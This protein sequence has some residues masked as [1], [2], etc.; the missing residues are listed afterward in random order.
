MVS[1]GGLLDHDYALA[2]VYLAILQAN[3]S[4]V[5][6]D[7]ELQMRYGAVD[8]IVPDDLRR[9]V[10]VHALAVSLHMPYETTRRCVGRLIAKGFVTRVSRA[11]MIA[12]AARIA[13]PGPLNFVDQTWLE[14]SRM[15]GQFRRNGIQLDD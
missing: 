10:S 8:A 3:L 11:G 7:P 4:P 5:F 13:E 14:A 2:T 15:V 9:P 12:N 1:L 6:D